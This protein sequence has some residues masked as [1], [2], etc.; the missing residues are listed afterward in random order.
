MAKLSLAEINQLNQSDFTQALADIFEQTPAIP[1]HTWPKRPFADVEDLHRALVETMTSLSVTDQLELIRAHPDLAT[2]ARMTDASVQEQASAQLDALSPEDYE[3]FSYLNAAYRKKFS[4]PFIIAVRQHSKDTILSA[5]ERRLQNPVE[6][7]QQA[8]L[9]QI[10]E[11]A[12]LRLL[13][14]LNQG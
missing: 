14:R 13:D 12:R 4:F 3:R 2:K 9:A 5:F 8:A 6:V 10:A 1:C 11:I 7:E